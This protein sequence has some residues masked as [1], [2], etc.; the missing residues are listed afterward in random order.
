HSSDRERYHRLMD[1]LRLYRLALGQPNPDSY[2]H[3][4]EKNGFLK[5]I[6]TRSL[7]L[8]LFPFRAVNHQSQLQRMLKGQD[9]FELLLRDA[10]KKAARLEKSNDRVLLKT[11]V[12]KAVETVRRNVNGNYS[13]AIKRLPLKKLAGALLAF[14]DIHDAINDRVPALGYQDDRSRLEKALVGMP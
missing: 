6:D 11:L 4:L 3:A 9:A 8:N 5:R 7:Y 1:R 10:D 13:E 2:L 14:V 12:G